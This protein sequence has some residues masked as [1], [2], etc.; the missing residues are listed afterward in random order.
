MSKGQP[1]HP[2]HLQEMEDVELKMPKELADLLK[3]TAEDNGTTPGLLIA[4]LLESTTIATV[5]KIANVLRGEQKATLA[6]SA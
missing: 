5:T 4:G 6:L 3:T 1:N 2:L